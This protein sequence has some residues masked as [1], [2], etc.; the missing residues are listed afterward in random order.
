[1]YVLLSSLS[2]PQ[3]PKTKRI[4]NII[5]TRKDPSAFLEMRFVQNFF[6]FFFPLQHVQDTSTQKF[7]ARPISWYVANM[8]PFHPLAP[9]RTVLPTKRIQENLNLFVTMLSLLYTM[10][11]ARCPPGYSKIYGR[12]AIGGI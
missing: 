11:P 12:H 7:P 1:M 8:A 3:Q 10:P 2:P 9:E 4:Q 6:F 5:L